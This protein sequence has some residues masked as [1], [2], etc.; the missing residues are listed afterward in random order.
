MKR[1]IQASNIIL[2]CQKCRK[3]YDISRLAQ[4]AEQYGKR[5]LYCPSCGHRVGKLQ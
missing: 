2:R 3:G 5:N 1:G 4:E